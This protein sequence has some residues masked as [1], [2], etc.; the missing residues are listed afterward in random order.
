M[1]KFRYKGTERMRYGSGLVEPGQ[2]VD[3]P[4][5]PSKHFELV[6]EMSKRTDKS[7]S[8]STKSGDTD[9]KEE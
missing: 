6:R 1:P 3:L 5:A 4:N 7:A 9:V 8:T 2:I